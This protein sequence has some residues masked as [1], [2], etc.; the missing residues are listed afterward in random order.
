L[1]RLAGRARWP[2]SL[3]SVGRWRGTEAM[4]C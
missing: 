3:Q 1:P 4:A 2:A